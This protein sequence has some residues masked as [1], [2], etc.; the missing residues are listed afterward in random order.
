MLFTLESEIF[1]SYHWSSLNEALDLY[2]YL[3]ER[4]HY[5]VW[6]DKRCACEYISEKVAKGISISPVFVCIINRDYVNSKACISELIYAKE[7]NKTI[8]PLMYENLTPWQLGEVSHLLA[9]IPRILVFLHLI[10]GINWLERL[11]EQLIN[12]IDKGLGKYSISN[13]IVNIKAIKCKETS[14]VCKILFLI[15]LLFKK[16]AF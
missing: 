8:I 15:S 4:K 2:E 12:S 16:Y 5:Y 9:G 3:A 13:S 1:L 14:S 10:C 6:L 7:A 11:S